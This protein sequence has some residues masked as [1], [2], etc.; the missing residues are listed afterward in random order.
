MLVNNDKHVQEDKVLFYKFYKLTKHEQRKES[1]LFW[2]KKVSDV[3]STGED[4]GI[5]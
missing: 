1:F 5:S 2:D 3:L 4:L